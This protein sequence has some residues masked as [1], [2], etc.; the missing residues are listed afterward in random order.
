VTERREDEPGL[1]PDD[2]TPLG[3]TSEHSDVPSDEDAPS[4]AEYEGSEELEEEDDE[5][6]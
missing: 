1:E 4:P 5:E 6:D 3:D 2:E